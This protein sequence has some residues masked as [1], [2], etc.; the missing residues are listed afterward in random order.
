MSLDARSLDVE[1]AHLV[2]ELRHSRGFIGREIERLDRFDPAS[3]LARLAGSSRHSDSSMPTFSGG[4]DRWL[5]QDLGSIWPVHR[6]LQ[7]EP[8]RS[9]DR[10]DRVHGRF[11]LLRASMMPRTRRRLLCNPVCM[12][13][14][15]LSLYHLDKLADRFGFRTSRRAVGLR[16]VA[17]VRGVRAL[18]VKL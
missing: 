11:P 5:D 12:V 7:L 16:R 6:F 13:I 15:A 17:A 18:G 14:F 10:L 9:H 4:G 8:T 2:V 1:S 3:Q